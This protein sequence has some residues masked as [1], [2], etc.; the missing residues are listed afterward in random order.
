MKYNSVN[1]FY[2]CVIPGL[3]NRN[4]M[5]FF[6]TGRQFTYGHPF[7]ELVRNNMGKRFS[8]FFLYIYKKIFH[9]LGLFLFLKS[10]IS[11]LTSGG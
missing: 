10:K 1:N 4:S 5:C 7:V 11:F 6:Q 2:D 9:L 3:K 8:D